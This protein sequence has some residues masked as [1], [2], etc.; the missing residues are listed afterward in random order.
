LI[1]FTI[2]TAGQVRGSRGEDRNPM[3]IANRLIGLTAGRGF[4]LLGAQVGPRGPFAGDTRYDVPRGSTA[5]VEVVFSL[6]ERSVSGKVGIDCGTGRL[7]VAAMGLDR[8]LRT[9]Q[10]CGQPLRLRARRPVVCAFR[11]VRG[12]GAITLPHDPLLTSGVPAVVVRDCEQAAREM[13]ESIVYCPPLTPKGPTTSQNRSSR[14][15][16]S[17]SADGD[18]YVLNFVSESTEGFD[19]EQPRSFQ[20][21][22]GHWLVSASSPAGPEFRR[23]TGGYGARIVDKRRISGIPVTIVERRANVPSLDA[24]H[25]AVVWK[26]D[27][28]TLEASLHGFEHRSTAVRM[29]QA[30][31]FQARACD[32]AAGLQEEGICALV[33]DAQR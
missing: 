2:S 16:V 32:P 25:L 10:M 14:G 7:Y 22:L 13:S 6:G 15:R 3:A 30:L 27:G 19:S 9:Q 5:G 29:A 11:Y 20:R 24:G 18:S 17:V 21:H 26:F 31:I 33:F 8:G 1:R 23:L 4:W 12:P 28:R